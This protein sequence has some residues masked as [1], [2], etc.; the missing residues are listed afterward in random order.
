[1]MKILKDKR[2]VGPIGAIMLFCVFLIIY[3]VW[4]ASWL[5]E[6]GTVAIAQGSMVG[7]EAFFYA[8]LNLWVILCM[9][10]GMIGWAYFGSQG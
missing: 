8:N 6:V 1:M 3:L 9:I 5:S 10:L 2:A 7:F 4:G